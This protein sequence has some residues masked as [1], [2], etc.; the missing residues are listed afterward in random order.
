MNTVITLLMLPLLVLTIEV[1]FIILAFAPVSSPHP[2][3]T[4]GSDNFNR[5][6]QPKEQ[7]SHS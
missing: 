3:K 4:L 5:A 6:S 7:S 2:F 1:P